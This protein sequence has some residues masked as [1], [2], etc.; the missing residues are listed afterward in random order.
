[1]SITTHHERDGGDMSALK[2]YGASDDLIEV[3]GDIPGCDEYN[4]EHA[5]F[6]IAGLQLALEFGGDGTWEIAVGMVDEDVPVTAS[7]MRLS[8]DRYTMVL[9]MEVPTGA[10]VVRIY[11]DGAS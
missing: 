5:Y 8:V 10:Y 9:D 3:E 2:F 7:N 1:M 11:P 6:Q 4:A